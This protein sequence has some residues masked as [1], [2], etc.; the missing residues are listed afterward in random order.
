MAHIQEDIK[1]IGKTVQDSD[2][3]ITTESFFT[4]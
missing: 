4:L 3:I 2:T 1:I